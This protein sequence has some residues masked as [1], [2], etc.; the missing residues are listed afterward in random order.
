MK[1]LAARA[2]AFSL[3]IGLAASGLPLATMPQQAS[4]EA[5]TAAE[6]GDPGWPRVIQGDGVTLT[7]YLPQIDY[8]DGTR[9]EARAA[10]EVK[11]DD[12]QSSSYGVLWITALT[13]VDKEKQ[14]VYFESIEVTKANFPGA[15]DKVEP[16]L[17][18]LRENA[19]Q[20]YPVALA[21]IE[22]NLAVNKSGKKESVPVK[23]DPPRI[24]WS[25]VPA[26]LVLIDG[27]PALRPVEGSGLQRVINTR[28]LILKDDASGRFL[29]PIAGTWIEARALTGPWSRSASPPPAAEQIRASIAKEQQDSQV[30][31]DLLDDPSDDVKQLLSQGGLPAIHVSSSPAELLATRGKP[32]LSPVENTQILYVTNSDDDIFLDTSTQAYFVPLSGRWFRAKTLNG[33]WAFVP[34]DTLP[35]DFKK[36]PDENPKGKVLAS[37]AGTPEAEQAA[38]ADEIPQTAQVDRGEAK[39]EP[40]YDGDPQFAPTDS[41]TGLQYAVNSPTPVVRVNPQTYYAVDN[42]V[43]FTSSAPI[44]PWIVADTIPAVIY[45]IPPA[46]PIYYVTYV[47][48]YR[49]TPQYVWCGYTPGYLGTYVAPWGSVVYGTG[50][51][52]RPWIGT[53]WLGAPWTWGFGIS[54]GWYRGF[55]WSAGWGSY[56]PWRPW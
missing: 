19:V 49:Y 35:P 3:T 16:Y 5:D 54:I 17:K 46:C 24:I 41:D 39:L 38:I 45:S 26:I 21:R 36:I 1:P 51:Y 6:Q 14:L 22:A 33:P 4:S 37:V 50:W 27:D 29:F 8:F 31:V 23:N 34:G 20:P 40:K 48:V 7:V 11:S 13:Q 53:V 44:G 32:Q 56:R 2:V 25:T 52:Y 30:Q 12:S 18:L 47:R 28:A 55:G 42:G 15:E 9:L 43:W 10:V